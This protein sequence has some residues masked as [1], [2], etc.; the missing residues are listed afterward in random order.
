M[1]SVTSATIQQTIARLR[2]A[3]DSDKTRPIEWRL[4]QLDKIEAL[5]KDNREA[6]K[7][8]LRLDLGVS[9]AFADLIELKAIE[10][11][12]KE[13][14]ANIHE[15]VKEVPYPTPPSGGFAKS[16]CTPEPYGVV[17]LISPWNYPLSLIL[18]PL[19]DAICAGNCVLIKPSEVS[20]NVTA[21]VAK[22][23]PKYLDPE[24]FAVIEGDAAVTGLILAERYDLI[25]YTG[26]TDVGRIVMQAAA[27]HITP[28]VLELGGKNPTIVTA[29]A[30]LQVAAR[31]IVWGKYSMNN[32]QTCISPDYLMVEES[33]RDK[34]IGLMKAAIVEFYGQ[35][36]KNSADYSRVINQ[37]HCQR[38]ANLL[39]DDSIQIVHGGQ[40]DIP[41]RYI[42]PTIAVVRPDSKLM[43]GEVFGP[44]LNVMTIKDVDEAIRYI[45]AREKPLALYVF[46]SNKATQDKVLARTS[47]GGVCVND[48]IMHIAGKMPFGGVGH[49]G[50]GA[51]HSKAGFDAFTHMKPV[52]RNGTFMDPSLR[53]PPYT[54]EKLRRI[55]LIENL[56]LKKLLPIL[57]GGAV[58]LGY[59]IRSRL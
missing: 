25:F 34:L 2:S 8:A 7:E 10:G 42:A 32:G 1:A 58:V 21:L 6:W 22:L 57:L 51:Y 45:N 55:E 31:R 18:N 52:Y 4:S 19:I 59:A 39:Q 13:A 35:D 33:V 48:T 41:N 20:V 15:W 27:K 29:D 53:Y 40:V 23:L 12:L 11:E 5:V 28:V 54:P 50:M 30:D 3:F 14:R 46:S 24:C 47:S 43:E 17:L 9:Q 36:P 26:N 38:L 44:I 37:H 16:F 49:S 56:Q